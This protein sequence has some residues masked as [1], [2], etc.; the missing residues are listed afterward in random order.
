MHVKSQVPARRKAAKKKPSERVVCFQVMDLV[1]PET[2]ES[3]RAF[4]AA[5]PI[6]RAVCK[7]RGYRPGDLLLADL[8]KERNSRFYR[9][10]HQLATF[11]RKNVDEFD[12]VRSSHQVLKTLQ[13]DARVE[14]DEVEEQIDLGTLGKHSFKR[15]IPRSLNFTDMDDTTFGLI[16]ETLCDHV[17]VTYFPDW[18]PEQV[19]E[20]TEH[21]ERDES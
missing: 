1:I 18:T 4:V 15:W 21:W 10:A 16:W 14:C 13:V 2:G 17:A 11:L 8:F 6:D 5:A 3:V 19:A 7:E 12:G 9:L 20:A